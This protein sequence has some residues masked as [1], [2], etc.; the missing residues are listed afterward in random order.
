MALDTTDNV[1]I[2]GDMNEGLLNPDVHNLKDILIL[3]SL[4]DSMYQP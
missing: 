3:N 1:I 4:N 2:V